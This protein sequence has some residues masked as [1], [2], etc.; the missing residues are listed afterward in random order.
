MLFFYAVCNNRHTAPVPV[1]S[2]PQSWVPFDHQPPLIDRL[3][4]FIHSE[5]ALEMDGRHVRVALGPYYPYRGQEARYEP[6]LWVHLLR[7]S[8]H[9]QH[10]LLPPALYHCLHGYFVALGNHRLHG[11]GILLFFLQRKGFVLFNSTRKRFIFHTHVLHWQTHRR[12]LWQTHRARSATHTLKA[13]TE[14][15]TTP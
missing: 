6:W 9:G 14:A 5:F 15:I 11:Q 8:G 12:L 13:Q 2:H 7:W 3:S 10:L 4:V 1:V